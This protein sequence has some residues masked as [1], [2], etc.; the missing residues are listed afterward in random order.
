MS[1]AGEVPTGLA[2][3]THA[4]AQCH[5][6]ATKSC[7]ACN[8]A[9]DQNGGRVNTQWYCGT[10]CQKAHWPN[11]RSAC[12][13]APARRMLYRAGSTLQMALFMYREKFFDKFIETVERRDG[14]VI[15]VEGWYS[16]DLFYPFPDF[17]FHSEDEKRAALLFRCCEDAL[18]WMHKLILSML[19]GLST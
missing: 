5:Q 18:T 6:Y 9:R 7:S 10:E 15:L 4:C 12:K 3:L 14:E 13:A 2:T 8:G 16:P 1:E 11:H 17:C 19:Q